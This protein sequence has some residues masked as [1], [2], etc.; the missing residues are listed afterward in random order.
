M[1]YYRQGDQEIGPFERTVLGKLR[2]AGVIDDTTPIK[3]AN[4]LSWTPYGEVILRENAEQPILPSRQSDYHYLDVNRQPVGPF[5]FE[6][7]RRLH[8]DGVIATE[9]YVAKRGEAQWI[10]VAQLFG[11]PKPPTFSAPPDLTVNVS[12]PKHRSFEQFALMMSITLGLFTFYVVP[13]YSRDIKAITKRERMEYTPLLI[14]GILTLSFLLVVMTV[15]WAYDLEKHGKEIGKSGRQESLGTYV[16][17]L[18]IA[19]LVTYFMSGELSFVL[20]FILGAWAVWLLQ[21]EINLYAEKP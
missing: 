16:L 3:C 4:T 1:W 19:F 8:L 20:S 21:K 9:T 15:L 5:D 14:F 6:T 11:M 12:A 13:S 10:T 7:L 17:I 2:D 18:N